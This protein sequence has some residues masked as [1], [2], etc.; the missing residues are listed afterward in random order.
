M[1]DVVRGSSVLVV[2]VE[3]LAELYGVTPRQVRRL[4]K[5]DVCPLDVTDLRS[6]CEE[7]YRRKSRRSVRPT[8]D[9][10]LCTRCR[11]RK[12]RSLNQRWCKKCFALYTR[13][14]RRERRDVAKSEPSQ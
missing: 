10:T 3:E 1:G 7:Y 13:G 14:L 12:R 6:I 5:R 9:R 2:G 4:T 11:I 8:P